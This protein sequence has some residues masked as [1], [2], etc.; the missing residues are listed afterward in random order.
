MIRARRAALAKSVKRFPSRQTRKRL[1]GDSCAKRL[2]HDPEKCE[3]V[4][5]K[6]H[7]QKETGFELT[8]RLR[9]QFPHRR[10]AHSLGQWKRRMRPAAISLPS[11][12]GARPAAPIRRLIIGDVDRK[13]TRLNSSHVALSRMPPSA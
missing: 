7:A 1:R 3:A 11:P 9:G 5:R 12:A 13:S 6:D 4:F 8:A 2:A 10:K